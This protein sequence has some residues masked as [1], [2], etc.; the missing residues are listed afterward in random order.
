MDPLDKDNIR[1]AVQ[2]RIDE[3]IGHVECYSGFMFYENVGD[4]LVDVITDHLIKNIQRN[5]GME[6]SEA[7]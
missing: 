5:W 1:I 4:N 3:L 6:E 7:E 2:E